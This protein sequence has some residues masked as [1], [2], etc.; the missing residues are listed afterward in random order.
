MSRLFTTLPSDVY[1]DPKIFSYVF[2]FGRGPFFRKRIHSICS[3]NSPIK[4]I[5]ELNTT[6]L[7]H[8]HLH[9]IYGQRSRLAPTRVTF[10][11]TRP[12][13]TINNQLNHPCVI[14]TSN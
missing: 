11:A 3:T 13:Q 8:I 12:P 9:R 10:W 7:T 2:Y 5:A 4:I 1:G 6:V 14:K